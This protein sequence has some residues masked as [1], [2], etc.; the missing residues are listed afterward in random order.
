MLESLIVLYYF[1]QM[2][3]FA[4]ASLLLL[5]S[6]WDTTKADVRVDWKVVRNDSMRV[7]YLAG[8]HDLAERTLS[9][10]N[11]A[12]AEISDLIGIEFKGEAFIFL[13]PDEQAWIK[14]TDGAIPDWSGGVTKPQSGIVYLRLKKNFRNK[15]FPVLRHELVHVMLG[16]SFAPTS[17]PRWFEEGVSTLY[18]REDASEYATTLSWANLS[19][20][21]LSLDEIDDVL[22][23]KRGKANLAY[24]QSYMGVKMII[25]ALGWE[26]IRQILARIAE[27]DRWSKAFASVLEMEEGDFDWHLQ[28]HINSNFRWYFLYR[29]DFVLWV[30][31]PALVVVS[32]LMVRF[33]R[34]RTYRRW[35]EEENAEP[36]DC[37]PNDET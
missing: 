36:E 7:Y 22:A 16:K 11:Q 5:I 21:L 3:R 13:V 12:S 37:F 27:G 10:A 19:N 25:D 24:A 1:Y 14:M 30:V 20:S 35:V 2:Q 26:G 29:S 23:F 28:N 4:M 15:M 17:I 34:Y 32:F 9:S 6:I 31:I 18:S 8:Y 33:R